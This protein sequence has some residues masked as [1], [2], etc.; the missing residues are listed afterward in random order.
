MM[1]TEQW[2]TLSSSVFGVVCIIWIVSTS[3]FRARLIILAV[4]YLYGAY[5]VR[6]LGVIPIGIIIL[7]LRGPLSY[8]SVVLF[9][10][11]YFQP[12]LLLTWK[13]A[14]LMLSQSQEW[15]NTTVIIQWI[16]QTCAPYGVHLNDLCT[17]T[18][19]C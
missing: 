9:I 14:L 10:A 2:I 8:V 6:G 5:L 11:Y 16:N 19:V 1:E 12:C 3:L 15:N 18:N 13:H 7:V 4:V 17:Y